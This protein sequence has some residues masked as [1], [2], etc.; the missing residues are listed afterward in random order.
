MLELHRLSK[1]E[2]AIEAVMLAE[3]MVVCL[4]MLVDL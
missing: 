2:A 1:L 4:R 3:A